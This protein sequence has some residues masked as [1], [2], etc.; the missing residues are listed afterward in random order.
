[1]SSSYRM[2]DSVSHEESLCPRLQRWVCGSPQTWLGGSAPALRRTNARPPLSS[3]DWS[4]RRWRARQK[5]KR[6]RRASARPRDL[7][8]LSTVVRARSYD[9][10]STAHHLDAEATAL[11]RVQREFALARTEQQKRDR[12]GRRG[13]RVGSV[14]NS[15][16]RRRRRRPA[17][18]HRLVDRLELANLGQ[19]LRRRRTRAK[20]IVASLA[21]ARDDP[22]NSALG[23]PQPCADLPGGLARRPALGQVIAQPIE[24]LRLARPL[25]MARYGCVSGAACALTHSSI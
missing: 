25:R 1:M 3:W 12:P 24:I 16:A 5:R 18:A 9:R 6:R 22:N 19:R 7:G 4:G 8:V 15:L 17:V 21:S 13:W 2:D 10:G 20:T 14:T 11:G 23:Q